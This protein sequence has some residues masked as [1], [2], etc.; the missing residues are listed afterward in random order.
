MRFSLFPLFFQ[1]FILR[2]IVQWV[3]NMALVFEDPFIMYTLVVF[4]GV[5][6]ILHTHLGNYFPKVD[7][8]MLRALP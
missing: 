5:L 8:P 3:P 6:E 2:C 4:R 7:S 1:C